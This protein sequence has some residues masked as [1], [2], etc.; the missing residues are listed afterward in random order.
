MGVETNCLVA[1][2]VVNVLN[3]SDFVQK[4]SNFYGGRMAL[5]YCVAVGRS[6]CQAVFVLELWCACWSS[7]QQKFWVLLQRKSD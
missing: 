3:A 5:M 4:E 1:Y 6:K 2:S 7:A